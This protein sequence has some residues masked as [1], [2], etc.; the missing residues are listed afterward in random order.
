MHQAWD[1]GKM[2]QLRG[3]HKSGCQNRGVQKAWSK[4]KGNALQKPKVMQSTK[5][6]VV[7]F[8]VLPL[9]IICDMSHL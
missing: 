8:D 9:K 4:K 6:E 3:M 2:T 1:K 7:Q 5:R